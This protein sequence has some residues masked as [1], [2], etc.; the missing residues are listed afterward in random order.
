MMSRKIGL[1]LIQSLAVSLF[2]QPFAAA[3]TKE[4][5]GRVYAD[6]SANLLPL[7]GGNGAMTVEATGIVAMSGN[8]PTVFTLACAGLGLVDKD[9]KAT[10][11]AYCRLDE[12]AADSIDL[13][14]KVSAGKGT[15]EVIGGSGKYAGATGSGK[16]QR[17]DGADESAGESGTGVLEL[18]VTTR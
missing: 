8:P 14:G 3:E 2:A 18:K 15:F 11:E 1:F 7:G 16:Y 9:G 10:T 4:L 6:R 13:K 5:V 12:T 17:A